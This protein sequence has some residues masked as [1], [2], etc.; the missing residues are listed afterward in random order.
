MKPA[1]LVF[2]SFCLLAQAVVEQSTQFAD[3]TYVTRQKNIYELFWHVDQPTVFHSDLY[4]KA[5]TFNIVDNV[6]NYNDQVCQ[7]IADLV[8]SLNYLL[9]QPRLEQFYKL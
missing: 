3:D 8:I 9:D 6:Y 2:A 4:Q 7:R 5:R 1:I